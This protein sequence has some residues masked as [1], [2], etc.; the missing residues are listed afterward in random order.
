MKHN[1]ISHK[2]ETWYRN[3]FVWQIREENEQKQITETG[4]K[5]GRRAQV[6]KFQ[7]KYQDRKVMISSAR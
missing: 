3:F 6:T 2:R 4:W 5:S 7:I 1:V